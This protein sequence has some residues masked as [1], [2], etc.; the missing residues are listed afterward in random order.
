MPRDR[1]RDFDL[2]PEFEEDDVNAAVEG[3]DSAK[4]R[5]LPW[6]EARIA[7]NT[8]SEEAEFPIVLCETAHSTDKPIKRVTYTPDADDL[9]DVLDDL[10]DAAENAASK[11]PGTTKYA[12]K[13]VVNGRPAQ[14]NFSLANLA[15]TRGTGTRQLGDELS[16]PRTAGGV[17]GQSMRHNEAIMDRFLHLATASLTSNERREER[18][19]AR[20][21]E[22]EDRERSQ[23]PLL[24]ELHDMSWKK[25]LEIEKFKQ[26]AAQKKAIAATLMQTLPLLGAAVMGGGAGNAMA[27]ALGGMA[28]A[29]GG[30][31]PAPDGGAPPQAPTPFSPPPPPPAAPPMHGVG[32]SSVGAAAEQALLSKVSMHVEGLLASLT[33]SPERVKAFVPLLTPL[34]QMTLSELVQALDQLRNMRMAGS[35]GSA[36]ASPSSP[37]PAS[38]PRPPTG[39]QRPAP[40]PTFVP[41][42][43][44]P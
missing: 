25:E 8:E 38:S 28:A 27:G 14:Q 17:L 34:D 16:D 10:L 19:R 36:G 39:D 23:V 44:K 15:Q 9:E 30:P 29:A 41:F 7:K 21:T 6:L 26:E 12:L 5:L 4:R 24:A 33:S 43:D 13:I 11:Y 40:G 20:I 32:S 35:T 2:T 22:L 3:G 42:G 1:D 31:P 18:D 37:G